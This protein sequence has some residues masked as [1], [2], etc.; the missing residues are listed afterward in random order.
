MQ[1]QLYQLTRLIH[2]FE[3]DLFDHLE[4]H[5]VSATLYAAPWFLT[6]FAS[7]FTIGFVSRLFG[8]KHK[9][10]VKTHTQ[11]LSVPDVIFLL[12]IEGVFRVSLS[13]L[14]VFKQEI[15]KC[16]SFESIMDLLRTDL[17]NLSVESMNKVIHYVFQLDL[18]EKLMMYDIEYHVVQEETCTLNSTNEIPV[19]ES[20]GSQCDPGP[21][22]VETEAQ[23][24]TTASHLE[25]DQEYRL[26]SLQNDLRDQKRENMQLSDQLHV[27]QSSVNSLESSLDRYKSTMKQFETR[28]RTVEEERD[29][30]LQSNTMIRRRCE[31]LEAELAALISAPSAT[32]STP[33]PPAL[34]EPSAM[35]TEEGG[36]HCINFISRNSI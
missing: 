27:A 10:R 16:N 18:G 6:L 7:Q 14:T 3:R 17:P 26:T 31:K 2:D 35:V 5:D 19:Y 4:F 8:K 1:L 30:L 22:T 29:A 11:T 23:T 12:G 21:E 32:S 24:S 9:N 13:L 25:M 34:N 28:I 36:Y 33:P 20:K 15:L